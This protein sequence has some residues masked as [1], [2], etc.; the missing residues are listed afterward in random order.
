MSKQLDRELREAFTTISRGYSIGSYEGSKAFVKHFNVFDQELLDDFEVNTFEAYAKSGLKTKKDLVA[1]LKDTGAWT[2]KHEEELSKKEDFITALKNT[3]KSLLIPGQVNQVQK[4][5]DQC[6]DE[7]L[8]I[9]NKKARLMSESCEAHAERKVSDESIKRAF[10]KDVDFTQ[11]LFS[12]DQFEYLERKDIY[13]LVKIYNDLHEKLSINKIKMLALSGMFSN[14]FSLVEE[15]PVQLFNVPP[16][17]LTF[18]QLNLLN[19]GQVFRSIFKN[20][21]N[22]PD[23]IKNNPD[24]LLEFAESGH[25]K[26]EALKNAQQRGNQTGKEKGRTFMGASKD[27]MKAMGYNTDTAVSPQQILKQKGKNVVS[28][29]DGSI[30]GD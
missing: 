15:N 26:E 29:L 18:F 21:P 20:I 13:S 24:K 16:M 1:E 6:E 25:K 9:R 10:Y 22:I 28:L 5:I 12:D 23:E 2:D 27:D 8:E 17:E 11:P 30:S 14:Y 3:K 19:Y 7:I 4:K